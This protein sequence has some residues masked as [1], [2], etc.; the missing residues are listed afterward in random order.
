MKCWIEQHHLHSTMVLFKLRRLSQLCR[1]MAIYIPLWSYSN[2]CQPH[3][4][5]RIS[6]IYIPLWSYSNQVA[7]PAAI[8]DIHLH[9]TMVLF[10]FSR[11]FVPIYFKWIYIPL[12]SYSNSV[13]K[14]ST[15]CSNSIYIPLWSY[16]NPLLLQYNNSLIKATTFVNPQHFHLDNSFFS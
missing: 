14:S 10:K 11:Y 7:K 9:S 3:M 15:I 1:R 6:S 2:I 16:S 4:M 5:L 8:A 12:W 13:S